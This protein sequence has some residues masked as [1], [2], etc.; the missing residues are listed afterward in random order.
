[1]A[2]KTM[3]YVQAVNEAL[4]EELDRDERVFIMGEDVTHLGS[5]YKT[6][7]GLCADY[8]KQRV[9]NTP[10]SEIAITG[11][12][13]GAAVT[14]MRPVCEL[15]YV[16]FAAC[17]MDQIA[18]QIA[19]IKYMF[20]GKAVVPLVIKTQ[21]GG[22]VRQA[23]QHSQSL[24]AWFMHTPGLKV[25]MPSCAA[26]AKGLMKT[27]IRDDNPVIF[28]DHKELY[29]LPGEVPE[30][31]YL[32]PF[33]KADIKKAGTD[34]TVIAT[35]L[36]VVKAL[37][38][39]EKLSKEGLSVEV[40]DPRTLVP[41]DRETL[42]ESVQKTGRAVVVHEANRTCGI[43]AE[44]AAMLAEDAFGYLEAPIQRVAAQQC[45]VPYSKTLEDAMLPGEED[46]EAAVRKVMEY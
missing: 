27:A 15:M 4:R 9:F 1:M 32:I 36:M 25:V 43:G 40:V 42:T 12:G 44:L 16:D 41:L 24:E 18:N 10:I 31:E 14:G 34:V 22:Y 38:V 35:S 2:A 21:Q 29:N 11:V 26:D 17:A 46:I 6:C 33:G 45:P 13:L 7:E 8:G 20:G 23:A 28:I 39:A 19:K 3:E 30:G 37:S 5:P